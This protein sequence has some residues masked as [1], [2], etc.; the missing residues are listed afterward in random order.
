MLTKAMWTGC[1][2]CHEQSIHLVRRG[3]VNNQQTAAVRPCD[4]YGSALLRAARGGGLAFSPVLEDEHLL[5]GRRGLAAE[6]GD[7]GVP[8]EYRAGA[9]PEGIDRVLV[10]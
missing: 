5:A 10:I 7:V 6:A 4:F 2:P 8:Q 1:D 9:G 3:K